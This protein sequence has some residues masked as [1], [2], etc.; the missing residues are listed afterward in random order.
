MPKLR[1]TLALCALALGASTVPAADEEH[2]AASASQQVL[3]V[4][5]D[6]YEFV[7]RMKDGEVRRGGQV[8]GLVVSVP[9]GPTLRLAAVRR[10]DS[11]PGLFLYELQR[12][13]APS[14]RWTAACEPNHA[15][16][17]LGF[18][19]HGR[20][21]ESGGFV[22]DAHRIRITCLSGALGKCVRA[23]Y[24]MAGLAG[25]PEEAER[26]ALYQAC[27]R[28]M[29]A[30]YCGDGR[31]ATRAGEHIHF[32]DDRRVNEAP[33]E[34]KASFEAGWSPQG[35]VCV[36]HARVPDIASLASV[37]GACPRLGAAP[38]GPACTESQ[39]RAAGAV[40]FESSTP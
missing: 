6:G 18:P 21:D 30:D 23:G 5:V 35:A 12:Q 29:R 26:L 17:R 7:L 1:K 11:V 25:R 24:G 22:P 2:A 32:W 20:T 15:G 16:E 13:D 28:M 3:E 4:Q 14:G 39:A 36:H 27:V 34:A 37:L 10:D 40:L 8:A 38:S 33:A 9:D 31:S 19:L